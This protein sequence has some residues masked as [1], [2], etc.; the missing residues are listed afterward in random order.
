ML[1]PESLKSMKVMI[2]TPTYRLGTTAGFSASMFLL[3]GECVKAGI[4]T[5]LEMRGS[6]KLH[7]DRNMLV[8]KFLA[9]DCTHLVFWDADIMPE[10]IMQFFRLL[11]ADKDVVAGIPPIKEFQWSVP[12]FGIT[13]EE[14]QELS[15]K[16]PFFPTASNGVEGQFETDEEGFAEA[17]WAPTMF[18][19]I[20]R[21]VFLR[22]IA[23]YP[24]LKF[25]PDGPEVKENQHLYW[26]FFQFLIEPRSNRE[27]PEDF[28]FCQLWGDIGGKVFVDIDS[29]FSHYGEHVYQGNLLNKLN[30]DSLKTR[31]AA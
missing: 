19:C 23:S 13:F 3:G 30:Y 27:L 5:Q 4:Q 22:L 2:C 16:Y 10:S 29:K 14:W 17:I 7:Y 31:E 8:A 1:S 9:S 6:S 12:R 24:N 26:R 20:K 15:L 21:E 28:S 18:L 11:L 25:V